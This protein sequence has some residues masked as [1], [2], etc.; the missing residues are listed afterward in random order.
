MFWDCFYHSS[1]SN[2]AYAY[3]AETV[4]LRVRTKRDDIDSVTAV[5]GDKYDWERNRADIPMEKVFAD[6]M[7]DYWEAAVRPPFRR[8]SYCF[9][10][11]AG[12]ETAWLTEAGPRGDEPQGC[13][14][15]FDFPYIHEID[16]GTPPEWAKEAV[17]YQIV[18]D[19]F[20]NSNPDNDADDVTPWGEKPD[21]YRTFGGDLQGIIDKLDYLGELGVT[22]IYL[23]PIFESPSCHK[24]DT[25][26]YR[27]VDPR[28]G[29]EK[30]LKR[31][32][33]DCH[34]RGIRVMLDGAFNHSSE[35]FFA[36]RDVVEKGDQSA[37]KDWY[38]VRSFPIEVKDGI[39]SYDTFGFFGHMPKLNTAHP[40]VRDYLL[41]SA[42][43]WL[44]DIGIDG[45]RLDAANE[46]DHHF[47]RH[48]R[49][50][51]KDINPDAY[52][53][54]EVWN[55]SLK[56]LLGDQFDSVMNYP[57]SRSAMGYFSPAGMDGHTFAGSIGSL[58]VRYPQQK[59]EVIFN[60]LCSH[61]TPR[62]HDCVGMDKR[63]VKLAVVF[64]MTYIGTP[65][66]FYGDEIGLTGA[67]NLECRKCMEWDP[68]KQDRE[69]FDFYRL[70]IALRKEHPA[71]RRGRFRFLKADRDDS[72]IVYERLDEGQ[73]FVVWM[74]NTE[75]PTTLSHPMETDDWRDALSG[76]AAP[77]ADGRMDIELEPL[78]Y[79]ILYRNLT[80]EGGGR[81]GTEAGH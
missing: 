6:P 75:E 22:A 65:C 78:G 24:Y 30:L 1:H 79:R 19:R 55:D 47:W 63:R 58:L 29:D 39:P 7:F 38:H 50:M 4:H 15:F 35:H 23:T 25:V 2:W 21:A 40:E 11:Q 18:P 41:E 16:L 80:G 49:R 51:V 20:A 56:W 54:G 44:R 5:T 12:D 60:L 42:A 28:F 81:N 26:D 33:D 10:M 73:H 3:D 45:W 52:I 69:L 77:A 74:N 76:E 57:F 36:F 31:L 61:D 67:D 48:F 59:N 9:R 37:Y 68:A 53:V 66:I 70:L 27:K 72:R 46:V 13:D 17:F 8:L 32:V 43:Y 64:L 62:L 71:L 14:G 34:R